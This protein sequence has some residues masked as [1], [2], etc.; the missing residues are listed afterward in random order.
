LSIEFEVTAAGQ[1]YEKT[2]A[3]NY[4]TSFSNFICKDHKTAFL[5]K[6]TVACGIDCLAHQ[7]EFFVNNP[8]DVK[9]NDEHSPDF[10]LR[11]SQ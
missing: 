3:Y 8:L 1:T 7:D 2:Q 10:A 11:L 5:P 4:T 9:E 6:V